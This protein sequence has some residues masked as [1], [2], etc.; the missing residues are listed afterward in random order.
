MSVMGV[1]KLDGSNIKS[2]KKATQADQHT[3]VD[4][5]NIFEDTIPLKQQPSQM[6]LQTENIELKE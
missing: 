5:V 2:E 3:F 6:L 4:V 1:R